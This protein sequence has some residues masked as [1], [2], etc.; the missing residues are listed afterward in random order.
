MGSTSN[1]CPRTLG[2]YSAVADTA[3]A[4]A[5]ALADWLQGVEAVSAFGRMKTDALARAVIDGHEQAVPSPTVTVAVMS[6][7]HITS[8]AAVVIVP[9]CAFGP[10][11]EPPRCGAWRSCSRINRR[12]RSFEVRIPTIRRPGG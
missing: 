7:P 3:E 8:G 2:R 9:S 11:A 1:H 10:C 6:V 12:T 4:F 5:D